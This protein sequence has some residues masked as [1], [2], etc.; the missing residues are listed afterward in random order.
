MPKHG[1]LAI[2]YV[3]EQRGKLS[4]VATVKGKKLLFLWKKNTVE[5]VKFF[6]SWIVEIL[7]SQAFPHA[8]TENSA[9]YET[10]IF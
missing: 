5:L 7:E 9:S 8:T 2:Y 3:S 1:H 6:E 10:F 4:M